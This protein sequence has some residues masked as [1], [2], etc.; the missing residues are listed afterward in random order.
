MHARVGPCRTPTM[1]A[2]VGPCATLLAPAVELAMLAAVCAALAFVGDALV[3]AQLE[4]SARW[5]RLVSLLVRAALSRAGS[6]AAAALCLLFVLS[7]AEAHHGLAR[8]ACPELRSELGVGAFA[9]LVCRAFAVLGG[10]GR[11]SVSEE[12]LRSQALRQQATFGALLEERDA[13]LA[14]LR[15]ELADARTLLTTQEDSLRSLRAQALSQ[16]VKMMELKEQLHELDDSR[17]A[18]ARK[19]ER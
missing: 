2:L 6:A 18:M 7:M 10:A 12:A 8:A 17:E 14:R 4:P 1:I 16:Q 5:R 15:A 19:K 3:A 13:E 11:R 9:L